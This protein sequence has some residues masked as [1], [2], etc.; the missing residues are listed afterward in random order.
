M[1]ATESPAT[2]PSLLDTVRKEGQE[3]QSAIKSR[4]SLLLNQRVSINAEI[5]S[6]REE[7][8]QIDRLLR[9]VS[10]RKKN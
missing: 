7:A 5:K 4:L 10:P 1:S 9:V 2:A 8:E 3:R 6:L